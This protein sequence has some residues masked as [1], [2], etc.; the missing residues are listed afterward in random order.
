MHR[1][2]IVHLTHTHIYNCSFDTHI[3]VHLIHTHNCTT[4]THTHTHIIVHLA[5]TH[6][7]IIVD[8]THTHTYNC[9]SYTHTHIIVHL[10]HTHTH[11]IVHMTHTY[12]IVYLFSIG[13]FHIHMKT[14]KASSDTCKG[15]RKVKRKTIDDVIVS[16]Y[17]ISYGKINDLY[18]QFL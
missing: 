10:T 9:T 14:D 15:K 3:I 11:I 8:L 2:I 18:T 12:N 5:H 17:S 13:F 6:T 16:S 4:D 7:H 1:H